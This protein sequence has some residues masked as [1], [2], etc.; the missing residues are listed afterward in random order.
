MSRTISLIVFALGLVPCRIQDETMWNGYKCQTHHTIAGIDRRYMKT[1]QFELLDQAA[2]AWLNSPVCDGGSMG[3]SNITIC[4]I[5]LVKPRKN[6]GRTWSVAPVTHEV[7]N[8]GKHADHLYASGLHALVGGI[9]N[10][11][12]CGTGSLDIS[13]DTIASSAK[14]EGQESSTYSC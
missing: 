9:T 12:S 7:A 1:A 3:T 8:D 13:P 6:L 11:S 2:L 10:K 14:R 4:W 5:V